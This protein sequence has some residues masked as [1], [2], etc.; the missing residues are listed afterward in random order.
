MNSDIDLNQLVDEFL[1]FEKYVEESKQFENVV[2][3]PSL[4]DQ[5]LLL[6]QDWQRFVAYKY[7]QAGKREGLQDAMRDGYTLL[8]ERLNTLAERMGA[9]PREL[10]DQE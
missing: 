9:D 5:R 7:S 2:A 10:L 8:L 6:E 1:G 3:A 4:S